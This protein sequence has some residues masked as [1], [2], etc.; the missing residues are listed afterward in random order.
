MNEILPLLYLGGLNDA[1]QTELLLSIGIRGVVMCCTYMEKPLTVPSSPAPSNNIPSSSTDSQCLLSDEANGGST[2]CN[3]S[4]CPSSN[5]FIDGS[6]ISCLSSDTASRLA[7]SSFDCYEREGEEHRRGNHEELRSVEPA[8]SHQDGVAVPRGSTA[9]LDSEDREG[10]TTMVGTVLVVQHDDP[11]PILTYYRVCLEDTSCEPIRLYF[12]EV[13]EFIDSF[14]VRGEGVLVH[15]KAGVSRSA[16]IIISYLVG[17]MHFSLDRAFYH[18][19]SRRKIICPNVGF[20]EQLCEYEVETKI[21]E[22][23]ARH[24]DSSNLAGQQDDCEGNSNLDDCGRNEHK[25]EDAMADRGTHPAIADDSSIMPSVCL[26]KYID[27]YTS[28]ADRRAGV[29]DIE[30]G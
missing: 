25:R 8:V 23:L 26:F 2:V 18:V 21:K 14:M 6:P 29:P 1:E 19:L 17:K 12:E 28:D 10:R 7:S 3:F 20:M 9:T 22:S 15:C 11:P 13:G 27:W 5:T 24:V 16:T 30:H 4:N